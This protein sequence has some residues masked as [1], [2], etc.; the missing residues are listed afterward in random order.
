MLLNGYRGTR[1][2][3]AHWTTIFTVPGRCDYHGALWVYKITCIK[4]SALWVVLWQLT[5]HSFRVNDLSMTFQKYTFILLQWAFLALSSRINSNLKEFLSII[6]MLGLIFERGGGSPCL[7]LGTESVKVFGR[8]YLVFLIRIWSNLSNITKEVCQLSS[9][10]G[11]LGCPESP[12][13]H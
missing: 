4:G 10:K 7:R 8:K 11:T 9:N 12:V 2:L 3:S 6:I 1:H 13:L 5:W